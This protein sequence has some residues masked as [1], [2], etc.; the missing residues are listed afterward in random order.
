M[1]WRINKDPNQKRQERWRALPEPA[2][3]QL[4]GPEK[5]IAG[6]DLIEAI[7]TAILLGQSLLLTGEPGCGKTEVGNFVAWKLG[8][9]E[10]LRFDIKSTT[11]AR[12][13]F[14]I[15]DTI[16]RFHAAHEM[17]GNIDPL[18]FVKFQALGK[19]ILYAN[20]PTTVASFFPPH[21]HPGRRRSVVLIDEID[22]AMLDVPNDL[23][24]EIENMQFY[25]P[26]I[27][28]TIV[29]DK[30]MRPIV[31]ITSNSERVLPGPFLRRCIYY[32]MPFPN[33]DDLRQIAEA[34]IANLP[35]DFDLVGDALTVFLHVRQ[36][37]LQ[38][39]PGTAELLSFVLALRARGYQSNDQLRSDERWQSVAKQTLLKSGE[40]QA[41]AFKR[42]TWPAGR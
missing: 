12:D 17:A 33:G 40:D 29:A 23:L 22:K 27:S 19:A 10:A 16:A 14:Y 31:I 36:L 32:D 1:D 11:T 6:D 30:V 42:F 25:M 34:R 35:R 15:P 13:L 9:K 7:N 3:T 2:V 21:E 4:Y 24:M 37:E 20:E 26:E 39:K 28:E 38:K 41:L 8:L 5:Y 18:R